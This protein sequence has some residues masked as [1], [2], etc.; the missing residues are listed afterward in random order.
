MIRTYRAAVKAGHYAHAASL[1]PAYEDALDRRAT[2]IGHATLTIGL[3]LWGWIVAG[4]L[5]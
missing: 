5:T 1:S 4:L 2:V 3:A